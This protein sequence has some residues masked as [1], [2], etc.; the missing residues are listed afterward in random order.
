MTNQAIEEAK[1]EFTNLDLAI[2]EL[3]TQKADLTKRIADAGPRLSLD[4]VKTTAATRTELQQVE[5]ALENAVLRRKEMAADLSKTIGKIVNDAG[6]QF[7]QDTQAAHAAEVEEIWELAHSLR[8]KIY[9]LYKVNTAAQEEFLDFARTPEPLL[10]DA[11][12]RTLNSWKSTVCATP[13]I[14]PSHKPGAYTDPT[15]KIIQAIHKDCFHYRHE[16]EGGK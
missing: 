10:D 3:E 9:E 12:L 2:S 13:F 1:T 11:G 15:Y 7:K 14:R 5:E 4:V 8:R 16:F 6:R